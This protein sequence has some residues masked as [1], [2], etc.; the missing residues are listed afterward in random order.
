[1]KFIQKVR[2]DYVYLLQE[3]TT[4]TEETTGETTASSSKKKGVR[5]TTISSDYEC[6]YHWP[7]YS[8]RLEDTTRTGVFTTT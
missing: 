1:M 6:Y 7:D 8:L 3:G 5:T 2:P 4:V